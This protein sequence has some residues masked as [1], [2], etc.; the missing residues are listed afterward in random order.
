MTDASKT[1]RTSLPKSVGTKALT[2]HRLPIDTSF[3]RLSHYLFRY[4]AKFHPPVVRSLLL[5]YTSER[6]TVLDP[7]C[8]SG[9]LMVEAAAMGRNSVGIDVD[10]VAVM[11]SRVKVHRFNIPSLRASSELLTQRLMQWRRGAKEYEKRQF[12][13]LAPVRYAEQ[14]ARLR[15]WIPDIPNLE[16]WFRRYVVIDLARIL[17]TIDR[18]DIPITHWEFFNLVFASIIRNASNADP[19]PVSGLEVTRHMKE[20]DAKGRVIDPFALFERAMSRALLGVAEFSTNSPASVTSRVIEGDATKLTAS[21]HNS[22]DAVI[23]S[24]PY[25]GAV[26]YYRRHQLEMFWL[27]VTTS[28]DERLAL[29]PRYIGNKVARRHPFVAEG[30]LST[31]LAQK[32][33][34]EIRAVSEERADGFRHYLVA[35]TYFFQELAKCLRRGRPVVMVVGHSAWNHSRIPTRQLFAEISASHFELCDLLWYPVTNRY[36]SY[37]RHNGADI[38]KEYVLVLRRR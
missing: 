26:D 12:T 17:R 25:H 32:W 34:S 2:P 38:N 5:R 6:D 13:D 11:V 1:K 31:E 7:F 8:G 22:V 30:R 16:H 35:M 27:G 10:P 4:P 21:L 28:Q 36:M 18:V 20:R 29:R 23:T 15:K 14:A 24:P 3:E 19:V 33:E 9:T 37:S